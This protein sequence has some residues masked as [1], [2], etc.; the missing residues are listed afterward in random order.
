[1]AERWEI[2]D[3]VFD[4]RTL[5]TLGKIMNKGLFHQID[6]LISMGKEANVYRAS[7]DEG[8]VAVKIYK[9]ETAPFQRR[10]PYLL[11]DPRFGKVKRSPWELVKLFAA[12]EFKNLERAKEAGVPAPEPLYQLNN[13]VVM[14]FL[15]RRGEP[16]PR[17]HEHYAEG[18]PLKLLSYIERMASH[19]LV[20]ADLSEY[21]VLVGDRLYAI[22]FGQGVV[23]GH[24]QWKAFLERDIRNALRIARKHSDS[25]RE[26]VERAKLLGRKFLGYEVDEPNP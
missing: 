21:N 9:V 11:G 1:M 14:S 10:L 17:L 25:Y 15:G 20:H 22:D 18:A 7:S 2:E 8:Y 13:V 12:K 6:H 5:L 23:E 19:G 24:P 26:A 16:F 3:L 4:R